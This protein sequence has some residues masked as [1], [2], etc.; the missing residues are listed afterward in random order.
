M[1]DAAIS[2]STGY[3]C[4][5]VAI[6]GFGSNFVPVKKFETGDGMFYQWVMCTGIWVFGL[7]LQIVLFFHPL[8]TTLTEAGGNASA[9]E[10]ELAAKPDAYSV[11]F[12]PVVLLGGALWATGNC[13]AVPV[14]NSIGLGMGLLLWG[15]TN[16]LTGWASGRFLNHALFPGVPADELR[17]EW[18]NDVGVA[19]VLVALALY[20]R[21]RPEDGSPAP[22]EHLPRGS[23]YA[24]GNVLLE[25][26]PPEAM[27][28]GEGAAA[29]Q[30]AAPKPAAG[31]RGAAANRLFGVALAMLSGVFYGANFTPNTVLIATR[32]G[33][34]E[35]LDYVFSH[36]CGIYLAST[37]YFVCYCVAMRSAPRVYPR[38][39]LPGLLSGVIWAVAQ[40]CWFLANN[41]VSM[42]IAFPIVTSG[43]GAIGALWGIFVFGEIRG[44]RNYSW[45]GVAILLSAVGCVLISISKG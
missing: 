13:C 9:A 23:A 39:I 3:A 30:P 31:S 27:A 37:V 45:L 35:P 22:P 24:S 7:V 2:P 8:G 6:L 21:V 40:T 1:P 18:L 14:I 20:T 29:Q 12:Y 43:P 19:F 33:S 4:I 36:F 28:A 44:R 10:I 25:M 17:T 11:K 15:C 5:A 34:P 26:P 42:S 16:M 41:A 38:L 32:H